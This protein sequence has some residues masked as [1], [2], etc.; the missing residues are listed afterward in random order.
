MSNSFLY[1]K[2]RPLRLCDF[3]GQK[4]IRTIINYFIKSNKVP[5]N[6]IFYG[7][8]G[9]GKTSLTKLLFKQI[10]CNSKIHTKLNNKCI[11]NSLKEPR[12]DFLYIDAASNRKVSS[13]SELMKERLF[14]PLK[15][16]YK[17]ICFDEAHML[18]KFSFNYLLNVIEKETERLIVIFITTKFKKIPQTIRSRCLCLKFEKLSSKLIYSRLRYVAKKEKIKI[19][20]YI[21]KLISSKSDGSLRDA[22]VNLDKAKAIISSNIN[23][24]DLI[25][26]LNISGKRISR[27]LLNLITSKK[28]S[29]LEVKIKHLISNF[30]NYYEILINLNK[31]ITKK[32]IFLLSKNSKNT[33]KYIKL[34]NILIREIKYF[35]SFKDSGLN[36]YYVIVR[37]YMEFNS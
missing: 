29:R 3:I 23:E 18:S 14:Y 33:K 19:K 11:C 31:V 5:S 27:Q 37:C 13:V 32:I 12:T 9:T 17:F 8:K 25:N 7:T 34:R 1:N 4:R 6:Y 36:F 20:D 15:Y 35:K 28:L 16:K 24:L 26:I 21:L 10:N 30:Y 22:L 2:Y